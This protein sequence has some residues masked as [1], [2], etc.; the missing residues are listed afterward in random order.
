M[1]MSRAKT[2]PM[3]MI[4]M[5]NCVS[6]CGALFRG[7]SLLFLLRA[8]NEDCFADDGIDFHQ[9]VCRNRVAIVGARDFLDDALA[10]QAPDLAQA[11]GRNRDGNLRCT[12]DEF[13]YSNIAR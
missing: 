4:G 6:I 5:K 13:A 11:V 8:A 10:Q 1:A 3:T 9:G 7:R 2:T 12:S